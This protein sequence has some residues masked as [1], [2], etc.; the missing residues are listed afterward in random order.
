MK[1]LGF[2]VAAV[3]AIAA[4]GAAS[5]WRVTKKPMSDDFI[6][7][8][9]RALLA[10]R[11]ETGEA[12]VSSTGDPTVPRYSAEK[13]QDVQIL[14]RTKDEQEVADLLNTFQS[15]RVIHNAYR[16]ALVRFKVRL[17]AR[18]AQLFAGSQDPEVQRGFRR[19]GIKGFVPY[20][21]EVRELAQKGRE[22][23]KRADEIRHQMGAKPLPKGGLDE[24][25]EGIMV[26]WPREKKEAYTQAAREVSE[27]AKQLL[28]IEHIRNGTIA[29][30]EIIDELRP[31]W[32]ALEEREDQCVGALERML[33]QGRFAPPPSSSPFL[34]PVEARPSPV[35]SVDPR[36][37]RALDEMPNGQDAQ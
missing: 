12:G 28:K 14:A 32:K 3:V 5:W 31:Q 19:F 27:I 34:R 6:R 36:I 7:A 9:K 10:I 18:M 17:Y 4:L 16:S 24:E 20:D 30:S 35:C 11:G 8:A 15:E 37:K 25:I 21:D 33:A 26:S 1:L 23:V 29:R 2:G 13:V 22:A